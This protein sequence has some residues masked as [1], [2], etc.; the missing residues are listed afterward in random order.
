MIDLWVI[1]NNMFSIEVCTALY[2]FGS[3]AKA[4]IGNRMARHIKAINNAL[5]SGYPV[6]CRAHG[7]GTPGGSPSLAVVDKYFISKTAA[8]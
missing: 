3:R 5:Q 1:K 4:M 7:T 2:A 6:L 8:N